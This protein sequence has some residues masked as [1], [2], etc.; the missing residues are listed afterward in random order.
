[1]FKSKDEKAKHMLEVALQLVDQ[2]SE[3]SSDSEQRVPS[4]STPNESVVESQ[5][6]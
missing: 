4:S 5:E 6:S 3:E 2:S 1:M